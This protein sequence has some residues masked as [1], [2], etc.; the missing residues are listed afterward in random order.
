M[1]LSN[2]SREP[3]PRESS[4][5]THKATCERAFGHIQ[6]YSWL[7]A[8]KRRKLAGDVESRRFLISS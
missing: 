4:V 1:S 6:R 2:R 3:F 5:V 7:R 8:E